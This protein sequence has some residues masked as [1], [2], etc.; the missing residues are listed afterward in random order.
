MKRFTFKIS[1][2]LICF[3]SVNVH[4]QPSLLTDIRYK[5]MLTDFLNVNP[6][7][8]SEI[9][10]NAMSNTSRSSFMSSNSDTAGF[11]LDELAGHENWY[12]YGAKHV[13]TNSQGKLAACWYGTGGSLGGI[14]QGN[15]CGNPTGNSYSVATTDPNI[16]CQGTVRWSSI[17]FWLNAYD[18]NDYVEDA[19]P[20]A[21]NMPLNRLCI[22]MELPN[23]G[24]VLKNSQIEAKPELSQLVNRSVVNPNYQNMSFEWGTYTAPRTDA[25]GQTINAE[26]GDSYQPGGS[27]FYHKPTAY[28]AYP[29]DRIYALDKNTFV[30]CIGN[31]PTGV[32]SGERP[33]YAANPLLTLGG[34]DIN[35]I[36]NAFS[37]LKYL[38]R[39][40]FRFSST[41]DPT[42]GEDTQATYPF[43]IK[44]NKFWM[45]YENND[46]FA[47]HHGS[48]LGQDIIKQGEVA[49]YP[50]TL[51]NFAPEDRTYRLFVAMGGAQPLA[52]P[53]PGISV[54]EDLNNNGKID[55]GEPTINPYATITLKANTNYHF[56]IKH[57][58]DFTNFYDGVLKSHNRNFGQATVSFIQLNRLRS[59][60]YAI[61]TWEGNE[62]SKGEKIKFFDSARYPSDSSAWYTYKQFN[63]DF[64]PSTNPNLIR[65]TP[66]FVKAINSLPKKSIPPFNIKI[67]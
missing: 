8:F 24:L 21:K 4:S 62:T 33:T 43:D 42:K 28:G 15:T 38:T 10:I 16:L 29:A 27:H 23:S 66:D 5:S 13:C 12:A 25:S 14:F 51:Y 47:M 39:I 55:S 58:I 17:N 3:A 6:A 35:G 37:Y 19:F 11:R 26:L 56:I 52:N 49:Y 41:Y 65:N 44:I 60:S 30:A 7:Y 54:I 46:I 64:N 45:M 20:G 1:L 31:I 53:S 22:E 18:N 50:F 34:D 48:V 63:A 2:I 36:T 61:R 32:R 40:Y 67:Q 59:A 9:D 57:A